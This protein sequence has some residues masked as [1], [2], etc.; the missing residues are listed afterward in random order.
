MIEG[1]PEWSKSQWRQ[2]AKAVR[3]EAHSVYANTTKMAHLLLQALS[4]DPKKIIAAY[5][6][7]GDE[8]DVKPMLQ[9]LS[10]KKYKI[11]LPRIAKDKR[12]LDFY[13]WKWGDPLEKGIFGLMEPKA[14]RLKQCEPDIFLVPL[15]A[16]DRSGTRLGHG[17]GHFDQALVKRDGAMKIGLGYEEQEA[18]MPLPSEEHDVRLDAVLTPKYFLRIT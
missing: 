5:W 2:A 7:L 9:E 17:L 10:E 14:E 13:L 11:A 3:G 15:L 8:L 4:P 18:N 6:P 1:L 16:F 12:N